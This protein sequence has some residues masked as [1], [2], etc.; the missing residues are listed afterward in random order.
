MGGGRGACG[1]RRGGAADACVGQ[2][3]HGGWGLTD[4]NG[5]KIHEVVFECVLIECTRMTGVSKGMRGKRAGWRDALGGLGTG[6]V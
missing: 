2:K 1:G 3:R 4:E 6:G 5:I